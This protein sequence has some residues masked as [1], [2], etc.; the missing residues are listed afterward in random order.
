[1]TTSDGPSLTA[2]RL[3][4]RAPTTPPRT[5]KSIGLGTLKVSPSWG[6]SPASSQ[7]WRDWCLLPA[8]CTCAPLA[9]YRSWGTIQSASIGHKWSFP[10]GLCYCLTTV[11]NV[12]WLYPPFGGWGK[13]RSGWMVAYLLCLTNIYFSSRGYSWSSNDYHT[14]VPLSPTSSFASTR[15]SDPALLNERLL[16]VTCSFSSRPRSVL[17]GSGLSKKLKLAFLSA[18]RC[19]S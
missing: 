11:E 14:H 19:V 9:S 3:A 16:P 10:I 8:Y 7:N 17:P 1:M 13:R 4:M 15:L 12:S 18:G 2:N 5:G 6:Q